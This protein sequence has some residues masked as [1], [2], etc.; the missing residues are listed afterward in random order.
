MALDILEMRPEEPEAKTREIEKEIL[1][2]TRKRE[3]RR[4]KQNS[5][6]KKTGDL[7]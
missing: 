4:R 7:K 1:E 6:K 3:E 5:E 2:I